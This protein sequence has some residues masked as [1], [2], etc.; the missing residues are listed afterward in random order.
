MKVAQD[1][2]AM[3]V[4][5]ISSYGI[6]DLKSG[7]MCHFFIAFIYLKIKGFLDCE[8]EYHQYKI[9]CKVRFQCNDG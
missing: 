6:E 8:Q 5:A 9:Y 1:M 3:A 4:E 2:D 7:T